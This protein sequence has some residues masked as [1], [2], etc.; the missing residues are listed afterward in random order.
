MPVVGRDTDNYTM[1][2]NG[3]RRFPDCSDLTADAV[4]DAAEAVVGGVVESRLWACLVLRAS[5]GLPV[6]SR[7][8]GVAVG[9]EL[10]FLSAEF[11][12]L[13]RDVT[14]YVFANSHGLCQKGFGSPSTKCVR[15]PHSLSFTGASIGRGDT[16][17]A[18]VG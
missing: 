1:V 2:R 7:E 12:M 5:H 6:R 14:R 4:R 13:V 8:L 16:R 11:R 18:L 15:V 3:L 17:R 10:L 9:S